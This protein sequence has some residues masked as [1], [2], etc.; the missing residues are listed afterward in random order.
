MANETGYDFYID[1]LAL[2]FAPPSLEIKV[3]SR[4]ET[5]TLINQ[6]EVNLLKSPS[7][8]EVSFEMRL[9]QQQYPFA[10][11]WKPVKTYTDK[12]KDLKGNKKPFQFI[13]SRLSPSGR[14]L[15][16]TNLTMVVEDYTMKE[17]FDEGLDV[18]VDVKLKEYKKYG[19]QTAKIESVPKQSGTTRSGTKQSNGQYVVKSGDC[20]WN[21]A[22]AFYGDGS[23]WK[24]IY[25]ANK[26]VIEDRAVKSGKESSSNG[27]WIFPG[28][29]LIIPGVSGGNAATV[30]SSSKSKSTSKSTSSKTIVSSV[31]NTTSVGGTTSGGGGGRSSASSYAGG[32]SGVKRITFSI[33]C[34][35]VKTYAGSVMVQF[36]D[37]GKLR[38]RT[39]DPLTSSI[40]LSVDAGTTVSAVVTKNNGYSYIVSSPYGGVDV[41]GRVMTV[42]GIRMPSGFTLKW[43]R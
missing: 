22:K 3:G 14:V 34:N 21:I 39:Y 8:V 4:N 24:E 36:W 12:L 40:T 37:N 31:S 33:N 28:T 25:E 38:T 6:G 18:L 26:Q 19:T 17:N 43:V 9:P 29:K 7:L 1:G 42:K 13:V 27:H 2:P 11:P 41:N 5:V 23:R 10:K 30:A 20:L 32:V 15:F 16:D 35:G